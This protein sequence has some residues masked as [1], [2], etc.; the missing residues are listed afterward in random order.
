MDEL[1]DMMFRWY[2]D[3]DTKIDELIGKVLMGI[4]NKYPYQLTFY[5]DNQHRP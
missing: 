5:P 2:A 3:W 4:K 1:E